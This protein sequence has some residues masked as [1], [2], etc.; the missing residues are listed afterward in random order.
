MSICI[1]MNF[2]SEQ[3]QSVSLALRQGHFRSA[4]ISF[5][6]QNPRRFWNSVNG[7]YKMYSHGNQWN[8]GCRHFHLSWRWKERVPL[9]LRGL[10]TK[11]KWQTLMMAMKGRGMM[12][13]RAKMIMVFN[14]RKRRLTILEGEWMP[15]ES[16]WGVISSAHN[17]WMG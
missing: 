8:G 16:A 1:I 12:I 7:D 9:I 10:V 13:S 3:N 17:K 15:A 14:Y 11:L 4:R 6:I 5:Y 2:Y